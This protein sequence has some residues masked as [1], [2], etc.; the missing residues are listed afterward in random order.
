MKCTDCGV[1]VKPVVSVDIDGTMGKYHEH[2]LDFFDHYFGWEMPRGWDGTGNWEDHLGLSQRQYQ[3]AKLAFRQGGLKRWMPV[4]DG[5][6][7]LME[8][9]RRSGA[10]IWITTTRP[11]LRLD[12]V[13]PD[14][15]A[16]LFRNGIMYDHLLYHDQKYKELRKNVDQRRVAFVLE[17]LPS[18]YNEAQGYFGGAAYLI[19]REHNQ[20]FRKGHPAV[21]TVA[22]LSDAQLAMAIDLEE[23]KMEYAEETLLPLGTDVGAGAEAGHRVDT[24]GVG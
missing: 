1:E 6:A 7:A 3:D 2:I 23:W 13:D 24:E 20:A 9:A 4:F 8:L 12:S 21:K 18:Q 22:D 17:D 19:E 11:Y 14:T 10:E 15:R 5:A 16:W